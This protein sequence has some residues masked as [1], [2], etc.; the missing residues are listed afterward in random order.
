MNVLEKFNIVPLDQL[1]G[2]GLPENKS[3]SHLPLVRIG[4]CAFFS[5]LIIYS[6]F[7]KIKEN[8]EKFD[9]QQN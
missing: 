2:N 6:V 5:G 8:Q 9:T 7:L 4:L 1:P 3:D